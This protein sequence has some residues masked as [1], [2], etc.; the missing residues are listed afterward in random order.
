MAQFKN[1]MNKNVIVAS[2]ITKTKFFFCLVLLSICITGAAHANQGYDAQCF[3]L[4]NEYAR[5][6]AQNRGF[7]DKDIDSSSIKRYTEV[8]ANI[9]AKSL[10]MIQ[11]WNLTLKLL[12]LIAQTPGGFSNFMLAPESTPIEIRDEII[13][14][15]INAMDDL[16]SPIH[17]IHKTCQN[18]TLLSSWQKIWGGIPPESVPQTIALFCDQLNARFPEITS[19]STQNL[20]FMMRREWEST[21]NELMKLKSECSRMNPAVDS[22]RRRASE[23]RNEGVND[24]INSFRT[25]Y[26]PYYSGDGKLVMNNDLQ[27]SLIGKMHLVEAIKDLNIVGDQARSVCAQILMKF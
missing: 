3:A 4:T 26:D 16:I 22:S 17:T 11:E 6:N 23:I 20:R 25:D 8:C 1:K 5:R 27:A 13:R 18:G 10:K 21:R 7:R 2:V 24:S 9:H 19:A 14:K 12:S 15:P